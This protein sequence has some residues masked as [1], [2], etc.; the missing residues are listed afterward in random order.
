MNIEHLNGLLD[1]LKKIY[2]KRILNDPLSY[3]DH[4][5]PTDGRIWKQRYFVNDSFYQTGGPVF[6]MIGG[7]GP[8]NPIWMLEGAWLG[9][10][11]HKMYK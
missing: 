2:N 10:V 7:E 3:L 8:A 1:I 4:F 9:M 5:H 11:S 6:I